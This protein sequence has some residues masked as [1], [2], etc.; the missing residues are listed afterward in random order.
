MQF[1][2]TIYG[3]V[4]IPVEAEGVEDLYTLQRECPKLRVQVRRE[5]YT[6]LVPL[7]SVFLVEWHSGRLDFGKL[8][9]VFFG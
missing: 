2:T 8:N 7:Q 5:E 9:N 3:R 4:S 6:F 1:E